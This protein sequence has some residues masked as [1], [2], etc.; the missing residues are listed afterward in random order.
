[1]TNFTVYLFKKKLKDFTICN[2]RVNIMLV[3]LKTTGNLFSYTVENCH[4]SLWRLKFTLG[5]FYN[6]KIFV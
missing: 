2:T 1:M 5:N 3:A 6:K 4:R